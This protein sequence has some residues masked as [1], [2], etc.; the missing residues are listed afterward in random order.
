MTPEVKLELDEMI[1]DFEKNIE[2]FPAM[3]ISNYDFLRLLYFLK[4]AFRSQET[5]E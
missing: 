5:S 4:A 2:N 1:K 3:G